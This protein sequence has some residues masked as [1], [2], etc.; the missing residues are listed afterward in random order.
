MKHL[1]IG[2]SKRDKISEN[3]KHRNKGCLVRRDYFLCQYLLMT[4]LHQELPEGG[5]KSFKNSTNENGEGIECKRTWS[6][7]LCIKCVTGGVVLLRITERKDGE[8]KDG[9]PELGSRDVGIQSYT[10]LSSILWFL[11]STTHKMS[12]QFLYSLRFPKYKIGTR[13]VPNH[14][15]VLWRFSNC[16]WMLSWTLGTG[17]SIN[18]CCHEHYWASD[19]YNAC[20]PQTTSNAWLS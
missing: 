6:M 9:K 3:W 2:S 14:H 10:Y 13:I 11:T 8:W 17:Y 4:L 15:G 1:F 20:M 19:H 12:I 5:L 18:R 16:M 7:S